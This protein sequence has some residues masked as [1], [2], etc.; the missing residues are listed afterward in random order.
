MSV[1]SR[2][3]QG[4]VS[5]FRD[6]HKGPGLLPALCDLTQSINYQMNR[7]P[8]WSLLELVPSGKPWAAVP[9]PKAV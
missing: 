2:D 5:L 6:R 9:V 7:K 3:R 8:N 1:P 4:A